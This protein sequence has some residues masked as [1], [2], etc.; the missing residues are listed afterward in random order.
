MVNL[1]LIEKIIG[2]FQ[3]NIQFLLGYSIILGLG[4]KFLSIRFWKD[5][6]VFSAN[7][8]TNCS[9]T[10]LSLWIITHRFF[11]REASLTF[12]YKLISTLILLYGFYLFIHFFSFVYYFIS[13]A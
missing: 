2:S 7:S 10:G 1:N 4:S 13:C 11:L 12:F 3:I 8:I 9:I 6:E 5:K